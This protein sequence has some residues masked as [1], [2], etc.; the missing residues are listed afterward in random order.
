MHYPSA[1]ATP[2]VPLR[3]L[4]FHLLDANLLSC[5]PGTVLP[6]ETTET[7]TLLINK[8]GKG[9][10]YSDSKRSLFAGQSAF[11]FI[12]GSSFQLERKDGLALEYY[13]IQFAVTFIDSWATPAAY[14]EALFPG[15]SE[16]R[17][18]PSSQLI[19]MAQQLY[20]GRSDQDGMP[21][22][23][24]NM[25]F[26]KLIGFLLEHNLVTDSKTS[27]TQAVE[28]TI[29][30]MQDHY[31]DK[32]TVKWLSVK[33]S[34][35]SGQ[36]SAVFK[37]LTGKKPLDYLTELR[38]KRA[39]EWLL[40]SDESLR[41]IAERVGFADEYYF[42]RRFRQTTGMSPRQYA[43]AM[44]RRVRV[45]DWAG[46]EV[47][48]P[49]QPRRIIFY[50]ETIGDLLSLGIQPIGGD[51]WKQGRPFNAEKVS[52][53]KPDLII[54]DK[55]DEREYEQISRIAPTLTYNS[56]GPLEERLLTL[57]EWFG[58]E[59]EAQQWLSHHAGN[60]Q[61]MWQQLQPY[62]RPGET[63]T[64]FVHHRGRRLFVMG[65]IGLTSVL[66]HPDGFSPVRKV[67]DVLQADRAYK[68]IT[69][70]CLQ[71]YA[72]DRIFMLLPGSPVS[73]KAMEQTIA[74][75]LWQS[76]P[77]VRNGHVYLVDENEWNCGDA[78]TIE[79][80]LR[81]LPELIQHTS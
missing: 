43:L 16:L 32:I 75:P 44:R 63:A 40:Q 53:L 35:P 62:I 69:E 66:Y 26:L 13:R 7:Y 56:Y 78:Y 24:N 9:Q 80:L 37:E 25:R 21:S 38:I 29:Q 4:S 27:S 22:F 54:F 3:S 70:D 19:E 58:K 33:A 68:E 81:M 65:N 8:S 67:Q 77:A 1:P 23:E 14:K 51:L 71:E 30:Y 18:Y 6:E 12:P 42:N 61:R 17:V 20:S 57:G 76:L 46:H 11:L 48:I 2:A 28:R 49:D 79:R 5:R 73:R 15:R 64:V 50:G 45:R 36:Y 74:S 47:T 34:L 72:G 59:R 31:T 60:A 52:S 10:L 39:K 41:D 55:E